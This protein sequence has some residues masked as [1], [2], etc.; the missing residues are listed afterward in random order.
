MSRHEETDVNINRV[1]GVAAGLA[2]LTAA[3]CVVVWLFFLYFDRREAAS[4]AAAP[5][6]AKGQGLRQPP[7]PRLQTSPRTDLRTF[8]AAEDAVLDGYHWADKTAGTVR[9][10]ISEAMKLVVQRGLPAREVK[11]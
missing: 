4:A 3:A 7:E 1:F 6:V 11:P 9:I 10:P 8:R 2:G 5:P